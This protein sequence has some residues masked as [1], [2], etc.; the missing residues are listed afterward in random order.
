[1]EVSDASTLRTARAAAYPTRFAQQLSTLPRGAAN[2]L[3]A[4]LD[5]SRDCVSKW[6]QGANHPS[7]P[8]AIAIVRW[9]RS[10]HGVDTSVEALWG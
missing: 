2:A 1:M 3:A 9:L 10:E 5:V 8:R 7:V 4:H 6:R